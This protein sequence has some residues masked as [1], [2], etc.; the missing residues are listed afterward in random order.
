ME[1]ERVWR[2]YML[3]SALAFEAGDISVLQVV[4]ARPGAPHELPLVRDFAI[5]GRGG[6]AELDDS[7]A[8]LA[9][10]VPP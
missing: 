9:G 4:A 3:G 10:A 1:R 8:F 6:D 5:A 2:L 7:A